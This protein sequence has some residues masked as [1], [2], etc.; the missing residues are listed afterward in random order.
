MKEVALGRVAGPFQQLPR[1]DLVCSPLGLVPKKEKGKY[2]LIHNLSSPPGLSVNDKLDPELCTVRYTTF[3]AAIQKLQRLGEGA[4]M[5]KADIEDAFCLLPVHPED[6]RLLGF[7]FEGEF[8]I[9]LCMPM[10]CSIACAVFE[11]FSRFLEWAVKE[12]LTSTDVVHYLDDCLFLGRPGSPACRRALLGFQRLANALGVPLAEGKTEGPTTRLTFL[13]IEID[14]T[15]GMCRLPREKVAAF[16]AAIDACQVARK[17]TLHQLQV[18]VGQLNFALRVIPMGRA[19]SKS[20]ARAMSGLRAKHHRTRLTSEVRNDLAIWKDF[21]K[22]FNGAVL[23]QQPSQANGELELFTDAAGSI[24]F[25]AILGS[26]WCMHHWPEECVAAGL[27]RNITFLELFPIIVA[28]H[29]W[30]PILE[31]KHIVFWS[32]SMSVVLAINNQRAKCPWVL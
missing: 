20:I 28:L 32:D 12:L 31:N 19:F 4:L 29:L 26:K 7:T 13:G 14:T 25:G 10:G 23:W 16:E 5:A 8:F 22:G 3:D 27:T 15:A 11:T 30:G 24:G 1:Q 21:L 18:L 2:R 17:V 9:D 6:T